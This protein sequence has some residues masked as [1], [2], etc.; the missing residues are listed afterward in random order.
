MNYKIVIQLLLFTLILFLISYFYKDYLNEQ[1]QIT[2]NEPVNNIDIKDVQ[3]NIVK[4]IVYKKIYNLTGDE[5]VIKAAYGEF[6]DDNNEVILIT[7]VNALIN[8]NDGTT[9]YIKSDKAKYDT[10]NNDTNF[11]N[12]VELIY[13]DNKIT[14]DILDVFFS[15]NLIQAYGNLVYQNVEYKLFADKMELDINTKN[16]KIFMFDNSKVKIK[17]TIWP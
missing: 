15:Q 16:T 14:S 3:N 7:N 5:F 1:N 2:F 6:I 12:N 9:V 11:T 8:R 10:I 13:L 4:N 17:K